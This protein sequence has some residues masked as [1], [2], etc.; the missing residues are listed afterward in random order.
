MGF[1]FHLKPHEIELV[2]FVRNVMYS[3]ECLKGI[4]FKLLSEISFLILKSNVLAFRSC[5]LIF[6]W[7]KIFFL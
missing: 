5:S 1:L 2:G 4:I 6:Y 7:F 3:L